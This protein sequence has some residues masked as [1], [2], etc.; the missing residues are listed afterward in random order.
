MDLS[1]DKREWFLSFFFRSLLKTSNKL[2]FLATSGI[3]LS[4]AFFT[5][6]LN[7]ILAAILLLLGTGV[8]YFGIRLLVKN[9][10]SSLFALVLLIVF[11]SF[12]KGN[13]QLY[14]TVVVFLF[15]GILL[16]LKREQFKNLANAAYS[17]FQ[18]IDKKDMYTW[19]L[20]FLLVL[21]MGFVNNKG[22]YAVDP[23]HSVYELSLGNSFSLSIFNPTDLSYDGKSVRFHFL[24][25]QIPAFFSNIFNVSLLDA[26]YFITPLFFLSIIFITIHLFFFEYPI[27]KT[28]IFILFFLPLL[29][30]LTS[31]NGFINRS[32]LAPPSYFLGFIL[33]IIAIYYLINRRYLLLT[34]VAAVL[35]LTKAPF[36]ITLFGG[37]FLLFMR[38]REFKNAFLV[39]PVLA[40]IFIV[41]YKLFLSGAHSHNL[42]VLV[43]QAL[44]NFRGMVPV[45]VLAFSALLVYIRE[46]TNSVLLTL[47]SVSLAGILGIL[48]TGEVA[49]ANSIQFYSAAY[50]CLPLLLWYVLNN[51]LREANLRK[52][53]ISIIVFSSAIACLPTMKI[54]A[55]TFAESVLRKP[56]VT[57]D[58]I[59][60]Y[61]W[62]KIN[63]SDDSVICFGKHYEASKKAVEWWPDTSFIRSALSGKQMYCENFKY[64]GILME[65][66]Y[67]ERLANSIHFYKNFVNSSPKSQKSLSLFFK[68]DFGEK[69]GI[70]LSESKEHFT[71]I[72]YILSNKVDWYYPNRADQV[73]YEVKNHLKNF[74]VTRT[75]V[76]EFI[77]SAKINYIILENNDRPTKFL[78]EVAAKVYANEA[79]TIL[80][81][82]GEYL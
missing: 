67:P 48:L 76:L 58:L 36:F 14:L 34:I 19:I 46:R 70:P 39:L 42:W 7:S 52:E 27:V 26:A 80:K 79:V 77:E 54:Y 59:N 8:L 25:T 24:S 9:S 10:I 63:T 40:L 78:N 32:L 81:I 64:K 23:H 6:G 55:K 51:F 3:F 68:K 2:L 82:R 28:P 17:A 66:D 50:F 65:K 49:E 4:I 45:I 21:F 44:L 37:I 33:M 18:R 13:Y 53:L 29:G 31:P 47:A 11:L 73:K 56:I 71:Q 57:V 74:S 35:L 61:S 41:L 15:F 1:I 69:P 16:F 5:H 12:L 62:L 75:W 43:P 22:L 20:L 30:T 38:N 72:L 60:A